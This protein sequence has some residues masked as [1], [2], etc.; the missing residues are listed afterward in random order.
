MWM[1]DQPQHPTSFTYGKVTAF[2][3][4]KPF[5][6]LEIKDILYIYIYTHLLTYILH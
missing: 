5:G 4:P 1:N 6:R 3:S 2:W